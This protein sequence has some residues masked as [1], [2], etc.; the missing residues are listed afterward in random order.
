VRDVL[1]VQRRLVLHAE[2]LGGAG[3]VWRELEALARVLK[4]H[5]WDSQ[6]ESVVAWIG[7]CRIA[8]AFALGRFTTPTKCSAKT[9]CSNEKGPANH[10]VNP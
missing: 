9:E 5:D 6:L 10:F 3:W 8:C 7:Q 4:W 1:F 2:A